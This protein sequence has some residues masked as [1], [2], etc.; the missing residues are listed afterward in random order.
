[1]G[2]AIDE[3]AVV[4]CGR[5]EPR[6]RV[7]YITCGERFA[8]LGHGVE[9]D[10]RLAGGHGDAD[11]EVAPVG[12]SVTD[13][14]GGP[15]RPLGV[16]LVGDRR[17]EDGHDRIADELLDR[18]SEALEVGLDLLVVRAQERLDV[19]GVEALRA[20]R[21]TD[22]VREDDTDDLALA[23]CF[24]HHAVG[25][26]APVIGP[27]G[28]RRSYGITSTLPRLWPSCTWRSAAAT[29]ARGYR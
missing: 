13:R 16:V 12:N 29:S 22:E 9:P 6:R 28:G 19:L 1:M 8:T 15:N 25:V 23:S 3:D 10:D 7:E 14:E 2:P 5:L 26:Y 24:G 11:T 21:E 20:C 17:P 18:A 27:P 4:R